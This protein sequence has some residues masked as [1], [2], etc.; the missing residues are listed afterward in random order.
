MYS[1]RNKDEVKEYSTFQVKVELCKVSWK[2]MAAPLAEWQP[3]WFT[4]ESHCPLNV[5]ICICISVCIPHVLFMKSVYEV[6]FI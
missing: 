4:V 3:V 5:P 1:L 2:Q 6:S